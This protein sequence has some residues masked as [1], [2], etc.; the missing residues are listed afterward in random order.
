MKFTFVWCSRAGHRFLVG[1]A[2]ILW[3]SQPAPARC[4]EL[5]AEISAGRGG[6]VRLLVSRRLSQ[7]FA[8]AWGR[9]VI[10]LPEDLC[11][12]ARHDSPRLPGEGQG[13]QGVRVRGHDEQALRW[14][15]AHEWA[16]VAQRDFR[17]WLLAGLVRVLFFYQPLLWWLRRQL[18][19]CQDLVADAQAA[20]QVPHVE[21]YAE[22]LTA[23]AAAGRLRPALGLSMGCRRSELFRRVI[24]LLKNQP[25]E[26]RT[27]RLWTASI[28]VA[29][30]A[31]V[32]V[33]AAV[34][35]VPRAVAEEKP[36][37]TPALE[38]SPESD[39][40][41]AESKAAAAAS[42]APAVPKADDQSG[43]AAAAKPAN[44]ASVP[45]FPLRTDAPPKE[46]RTDEI[47]KGLPYRWDNGTVHIL[48]WEVT[49]DKGDDRD[50]QM[51]DVLVLKSFDQPIEKG[52]CRWVLRAPLPGPEGQGPA[53]ASTNVD[54][55]PVRIWRA[56][57]QT[58]RRPIVRI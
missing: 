48:A 55:S 16:H 41:A 23:R 57:A 22:F 37:I 36:A 3:T 40:F 4:R 44:E 1:L 17:T 31:L 43:E 42:P 56:D 21:D 25:L 9:A 54:H 10:V 51:T 33:A 53:L 19:L 30:L 32:A 20:R 29:A 2:R 28:T 47:N 39:Q 5:L 6:R 26:S 58:N 50:V 18:R 15:L 34:S 45:S 14:C 38:A 7:P 11:G 27:P 52:G 8:S 49:E 35:L 46:W 12:D 24:M 13:G